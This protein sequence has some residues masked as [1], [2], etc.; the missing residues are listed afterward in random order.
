M[1][2]TS[3]L[4]CECN[5]KLYKNNKSLEEHKQTNTHKE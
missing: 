1:E 4:T 5:G 3:Q 2:L